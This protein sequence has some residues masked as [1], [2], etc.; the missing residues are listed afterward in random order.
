MKISTKKI[1]TL[2]KRSNSNVGRT[3]KN[4]KRHSITTNSTDT[5]NPQITL[6]INHQSPS[7][8]PSP[9]QQPNYLHIN[10]I[11]GINDEYR[12]ANFRRLFD[13]ID[14]TIHTIHTNNT[15]NINNPGIFTKLD[16]IDLP[17]SGVMCRNMTLSSPSSETNTR[18]SS[19]D[20]P[21]V[22][23]NPSRPINHKL[24][25][26]VH[27]TKGPG[28]KN[29]N[30]RFKT[31]SKPRIRNRHNNINI[32]SNNNNSNNNL[33]RHHINNNTRNRHHNN[34]NNN[35]RNRHHN[36][37]NN[38]YKMRGGMVPEDENRQWTI[39]NGIYYIDTTRLKDS[40]KVE[41]Y[42]RDKP[43]AVDNVSQLDNIKLRYSPDYLYSNP[44]FILDEDIKDR[45]YGNLF[46]TIPTLYGEN[47]P[48]YILFQK[49]TAKYDGTIDN[50]KL[51]K[52]GRDNNRWDELNIVKHLISLNILKK[53]K[54]LAK[55]YL[56]NLHSNSDK[57]WKENNIIE[58][59]K[60]ITAFTVFDGSLIE[61]D[62]PFQSNKSN[63]YDDY[64]KKLVNK[65]IEI[66]KTVSNI[67]STVTT[68]K[69]ETLVNKIYEIERIIYKQFTSFMTT[70]RAKPSFIKNLNE[71]NFELIIHYLNKNDLNP[72][73]SAE[74]RTQDD[75]TGFFRNVNRDRIK[76]IT[77]W[78]KNVDK[79]SLT[80]QTYIN[81]VNND[82]NMKKIYE[83]LK[84]DIMPQ[85]DKF[86]SLVDQ[87][88][89]DMVNRQIGGWI[90]AFGVKLDI[91][92]QA[93]L[94]APN[95]QSV[96]TPTP[97]EQTAVKP[98]TGVSPTTEGVPVVN[99]KADASRSNVTPAPASTGTPK[100]L[101]TTPNTD[102]PIASSGQVTN[103]NDVSIIMKAIMDGPDQ[104]KKTLFLRVEIP[105]GAP[106]ITSPPSGDNVDNAIKHMFAPIN[107]STANSGV[108]PQDNVNKINSPPSNQ[109]LPAQN[110]LLSSIDTLKRSLNDTDKQLSTLKAV[111]ASKANGSTVATVANQQQQINTISI[112][113]SQLP[114]KSSTS[115]ITLPP[116]RNVVPSPINP[117][118]PTESI[119]LSVTPPP[120]PARSSA[121]LDTPP[122]PR[123]NLSQT[124]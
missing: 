71:T 81:T 33:N 14:E 54:L 74:T 87:W 46:W 65:F 100:T 19:H 56:D 106:F 68:A 78:Y 22:A 91:P 97:V 16:M 110:V 2:L 117:Q 32:N 24:K 63:P 114:D 29:T 45:L 1:I 23:K 3:Q 49:A 113:N 64:P 17:A 111:E 101:E 47:H 119:T 86:K 42:Y 79:T 37:K 61:T 80:E 92:S 120:R 43:F 90:S 103:T 26:T 9:S 7:P 75:P 6:Q 73:S 121:L 72:P 10:G 36:N 83:I 85:V 55:Q 96:N 76:E 51:A 27:N 77:D 123:Q 115:P 39:N 44:I 99:S 98:T 109:S 102:P 58:L 84:N 4:G 93:S 40:S 57:T 69:G 67:C 104:S 112:Q 50:K 62:P 118:L 116:D 89:S 38:R 28:E 5:D 20:M 12:I 18:S 21:T 124:K 59:G 60:F 108:I 95:P 41:W 30:L 88:R 13:A 122:T 70:S 31:I 52:D 82:N 105:E 11:N 35:T 8:S 66:F 94:Q 25:R 53:T 34:K 15:D 48:I 107:K